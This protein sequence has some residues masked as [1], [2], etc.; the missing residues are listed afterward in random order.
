MRGATPAPVVGQLPGGVESVTGLADPL[1][2]AVVVGALAFLVGAWVLRS[3]LRTRGS[4]LRRRLKRLDEVSVLMHPNPDPDAM[5]CA[6]AVAHLAESVETDAVLQYPGEIRHQENRAFRTGLLSGSDENEEDEFECE[7]IERA[8]DIVSEDVVL[9]DHNE[10]RGFVGSEAVDPVVVIDHH[11]GNGTGRAFTDV[12]PDYGACASIIAE[13]FRDL[14]AEPVP[15]RE[16]AEG[17]GLTLT[18]N[19]ATGLVY[20]ILSDTKNLTNGCSSADFAAMEYLYPAIDEDELGDIADP[21]VPR[22]VLDVK[23]AAIA[24]LD[25]KPP[26]VVSNVGT[27]SNSDAIPQAADELLRLEGITAVVVFGERAGKIHLSGR[28]RDA[29]VHMGRALEAAVEDIP[30]S[31]AGGHARMGGGTISVD[32][33]EGLGPSEGVSRT[34]LTRRLFEA[35]AEE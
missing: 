9:V 30:M 4:S 16:V 12:R 26:F 24:N 11:P 34:D 31:S 2:V 20:G 28:S 21:G 32:H 23:A 27:V 14:D 15:P 22:D 25:I 5:A 35:M 7:S 19:V 13:Y 29:K 8:D 3:R 6:M 33:M 1:V 18:A 10:P 17:D